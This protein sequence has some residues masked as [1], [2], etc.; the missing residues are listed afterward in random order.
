MRFSLGT[1]VRSSIFTLLTVLASQ[2]LVFAQYTMLFNDEFNS[3]TV[4]T[5][6]WDDGSWQMGRTYLSNT[7]KIQKASG[8]SFA[9][10]QFDTYN[11]NFPGSLFRGGEFYS[12]RTFP[13]PKTGQGLK[14]EARVR[15][16]TETRG[17]VASFFT[18]GGRRTATT[19]LSDEV[20]FE[21]L[22]SYPANHLLLT[23]WNDWDYLTPTY[24]DNIHH[25]DSLVAVGGLNRNAWT[26]LQLRW[27][28]DRLEWY[29][30]GVLAWSTKNAHPNDPMGVRFSFWAPEA[31]WIGVYDHGLQPALSRAQNRSYF[32]DI[33]YVRVSKIP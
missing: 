17:L 5:Y 28:K 10:L 14:F 19:V 30:N 21:Y 31:K 15:V 4:D 32:F 2:G 3:S 7:A 25:T 27:L 8:L 6:K 29:V 18:W 33:D 24:R 12:L 20:D 11:P 1:I 9:T 13:F 22:T 23:S 26:T 16:R